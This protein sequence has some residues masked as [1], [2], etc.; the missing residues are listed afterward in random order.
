MEPT[1]SQQLNEYMRS[2]EDEI[3]T[4]MPYAGDQRKFFVTLSIWDPDT[5]EEAGEVGSV[6]RGVVAQTVDIGIAR[7]LDGE[8]DTE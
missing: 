7:L 4:I 2:H 8:T 5:E 1:I 3:L 6:I